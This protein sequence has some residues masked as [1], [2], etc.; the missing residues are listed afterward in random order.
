MT[1]TEII[2]RPLH[3]GDEVAL[4]TEANASAYIGHISADEMAA[5]IATETVR[6]IYFDGKAVGFGVWLPISDAWCEVGPF[7]VSETMQGKGLGKLI[8][9]TIFNLASETGFNLFAVSKN[10][11][12]QH[13]L[14]R[15]AFQRVKF[16]ALPG[17]I[18]RY[19]GAKVTLRRFVHLIRK[20]SFQPA[21]CY[22]RYKLDFEHDIDA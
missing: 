18:R 1:I 10:A 3:S 5:W 15:A 4:R 13:V 17:E 21:A 12:M 11:A 6:F 22:L 2:P 14:E 16:W 8:S 19:L 9:T 20:F 7:Y